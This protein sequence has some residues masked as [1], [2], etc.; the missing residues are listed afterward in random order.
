[1]MPLIGRGLTP[2]MTVLAGHAAHHGG[3]ARGTLS[4]QLLVKPLVSA[5][6]LLVHLRSTSAAQQV[7]LHLLPNDRVL[8]LT[9]PS[10]LLVEQVCK[11]YPLPEL[12]NFNTL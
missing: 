3:R 7:L 12:W 8:S 6:R 5:P 4:P 1:M 11:G 9:F 2:Q 10:L